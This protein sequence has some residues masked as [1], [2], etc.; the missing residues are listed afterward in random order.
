M[1]STKKKSAT[2]AKA[3]ASHSDTTS[4]HDATWVRIGRIIRI[5]KAKTR[6]GQKAAKASRADLKLLLEWVA[7]QL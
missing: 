4:D 5:K 3:D 1:A 2:R 6:R 7:T